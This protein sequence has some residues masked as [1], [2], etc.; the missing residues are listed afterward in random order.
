MAKGLII[1]FL[2]FLVSTSAS[3]SSSGVS[4]FPSKQ[5]DS[6]DLPSVPVCTNVGQCANYCRCP[7]DQQRC[8][9]N[10]CYCGSNICS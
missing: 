2:L 5:K 6:V 4:S 8:T 10:H 7:V 3:G 1:C 9:N